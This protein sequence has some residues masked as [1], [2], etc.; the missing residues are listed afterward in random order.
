VSRRFQS[1]GALREGTFYV[2]RSADSELPDALCRG[3]L[4]HVLAPR[5]MGKSSLRLRV[6]AVLR[7]RGVCSCCVDLSA[8]GSTEVTPEQWYFG[9]VDALARSLDLPDPARF[10]R[11]KGLLSP[12]LRWSRYL[13]S[14]IVEKVACPVVIFLDE[15]DAVRSLPFSA[16]DF[17]ASIRFLFNSRAD[18]PAFE[19]LRFC[20][21]G[22]ATPGELMRDTA[23]TPFNVGRGVRL[24]DFSHAEAEAFLPGLSDNADEAY[25]LLDNILHWTSGHPYMTHR[26]CEK[27]A[28]ESVSGD[29]LPAKALVSRLVGDLFQRRGRVEDLCLSAV[30]RVFTRGRSRPRVTEMLTLYQRLVAEDRVLAVSDDPVQTAL[31]LAGLAAERDDGASVWVQVRNPIVANVFDSAWVS[32]RLAAR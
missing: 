18:D 28:E 11:S 32:E 4:C 23:R 1:G 31:C 7:A 17:F 13:Q 2:S 8:L 25:R 14:E 24:A 5:Q 16:D 20:M 22:V 29:P 9:L 3:E 10:W 26:I 19:R 27:L 30:E 15:I 6:D 21:M 12:G